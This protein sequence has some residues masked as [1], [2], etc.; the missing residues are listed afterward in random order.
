MADTVS[1]AAAEAVRRPPQSIA[2]EQSILGGLMIDNKALDSVLDIVQP[3]DFAQRSHRLIYEQIVAM[4]Q[5]GSPADVLTV[6]EA[7]R[8]AGTETEAGGLAYLNELVNN[9]P[10]AANIRRY[11][12]IVHDKSVLRQLITVGDKMVTSALS[13]EG[14]DTA[15]ILEDAERDV[16]A[17]NERNSRGKRGFQPM[18]SL[19]RT[20]S[21]RIVSIYN[22]QQGSDVTG[23]PSGYPNL[24]RELAGLQR[25]DL[26]VIAGRPSMGKTALALNIAENVGVRLGLPVAIFSLEM[27]AEQLAQRLISSVANIDAQKLRKARLEDEEWG[28]FTKALKLLE[29]K[30]IYIDDTPGLLAS[31]IGSRARRLSNQTGQLGLIV[32]DYIQLIPGRSN[33]ENRSTELSEISRSLKGLAK[34]LNCP[35]IVLSQLNRSVENRP[36]KRPIMADLR[37]SGAIEQ[38]A[39]VIMFIYRDVVYNKQTPEKNL[40]EIIIGKQRNGPIG[41]LR[42]VFRG[43]NTRFE[44]WAGD[45]GYWD[46]A[47]DTEG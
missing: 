11:A 21:E 28:N 6:D 44:P 12:E 23:V 10:S 36:D 42:M 33:S 7:L 8:S 18:G 17:I 9:T 31:E 14:R 25:G 20:V 5:K 45:T 41:T 24:D 15:Q 16:L 32:V 38:D 39:D 26:I 1:D 2:S 22:D 30:P 3:E 43:G 37:E 27:G 34:E 46:G 47:M 29:D 35:V 40:A 19:V 13:P 4:I